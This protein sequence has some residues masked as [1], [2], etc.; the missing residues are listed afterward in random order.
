MLWFLFV[1][2]SYRDH[3]NSFLR[4]WDR[5][6]DG[7]HRIAL[8]ALLWT[9]SIWSDSSLELGSQTVGR[10]R[11]LHNRLRV[12]RG[13]CGW[14]FLTLLRAPYA[15]DVIAL[16]WLLNDRVESSSTPRYR[17]SSKVCRGE[18]SNWMCLLDSFC[19]PSNEPLPA[20]KGQ[21]TRCSEYKWMETG[22]E[23]KANSS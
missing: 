4:G 5:V 3:P 23:E 2:V 16:M 8:I 9:R 20:V 21:L 14:A 12:T 7:L 17:N 18:P 13:R 6:P 19:T 11:D 1:A 15:R 10:T 22:L